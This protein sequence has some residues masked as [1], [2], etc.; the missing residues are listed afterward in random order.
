MD[1]QNNQSAT[2]ALAHKKLHGRW[3]GKQGK[4]K[5]VCKTVGLALRGLKSHELPL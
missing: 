2:K 3:T 5:G 1:G 4:D